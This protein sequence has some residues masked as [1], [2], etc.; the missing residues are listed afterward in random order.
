[1]DTK[2]NIQIG[3]RGFIYTLSGLLCGLLLASPA[4]LMAAKTRIKNL[5]SNLEIEILEKSRPTRHPSI[6]SH[7][8]GDKT[9]LY[10]GGY[11]KARPIGTMNQVGR[12]IWEG[13]NGKN[14]PQDLSKLVHQKYLVSP[15]QAHV[16]CLAFLGVLKTKGAIEL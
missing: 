1:M 12:T 7:S 2:E 3:R 8:Y 9:T 11:G 5:L 6:T 16:D 13:C 4:R 10:R 15:H 14:T